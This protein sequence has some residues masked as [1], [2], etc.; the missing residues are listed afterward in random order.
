MNHGELVSGLILGGVLCQLAHLVGK[1]WPRKAPF[2]SW[3]GRKRV[4]GGGRCPE[5]VAFTGQGDD[6]AGPADW[7]KA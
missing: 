4:P 1:A 7:P 3:C 5:C 6:V 2:C